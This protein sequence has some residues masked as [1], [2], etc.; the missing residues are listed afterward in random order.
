MNL[1]RHQ[2]YDVIFILLNT[3]KKQFYPPKLK[4]P[5]KFYILVKVVFRKVPPQL[6]KEGG[7]FTRGAK[8]GKKSRSAPVTLSPEMFN[9]F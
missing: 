9:N 4:F 5:I 3:L 2:V 7:K 6:K 8:I 1:L